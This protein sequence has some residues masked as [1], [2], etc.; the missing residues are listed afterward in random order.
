MVWPWTRKYYN[1]NAPKFKF[2]VVKITLIF[3]LFLILLQAFGVLFNM[4]GIKL[5]PVFQ[6][7]L[8]AAIALGAFAIGKKLLQ[9]VAVSKKDI[10]AIVVLIVICALALFFVRDLIPEIFQQSMFEAKIML[11]SYLPLP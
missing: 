9:G 10:F 5:G 3:V 6:L 8:I 1:P 4:Q 7:I 2:D 11:Q